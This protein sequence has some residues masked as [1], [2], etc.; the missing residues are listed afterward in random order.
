MWE[1][2]VLSQRNLEDNPQYLTQM[3]SLSNTL[4]LSQP[5]GFLGYDLGDLCAC[6]CLSLSYILTNCLG[7]C[8]NN[9]LGLNHPN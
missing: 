3:D 1:R 9:F 5:C 7:Q 2:S 4:P 6:V 8:C